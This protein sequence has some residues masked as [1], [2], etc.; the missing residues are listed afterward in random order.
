MWLYGEENGERA[1]F[2]YADLR[3]ADLSCIDLSG[4][5]FTGADLTGA[6]LSSANLSGAVLDDANLEGANLSGANLREAH[7]S[8][9]N[10]KNV[11]TNMFTVGYHLECPEEGSFVAYKKAGN[12]L[13]KLLVLGDAKRSS[14]TTPKCRC[15]KAK[16][17]EIE[18]LRTGLKCM[19]AISNYDDKFIYRVGEIVKVDNFDDDRW[20]E[21][22]PGIHFF[23]NREN[24]INY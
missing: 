19:Q 16:V 22:A 13:V 11:K 8:H 4:A 12:C 5:I 23:M 18:N 9:A 7:L 24:A 3:N 10:L 20:N 1:N 21:C 6:N 15:D 14:G 17:L 2:R